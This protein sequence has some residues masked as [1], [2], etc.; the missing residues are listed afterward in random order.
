M[1]SI[2]NVQVMPGWTDEDI[3]SVAQDRAV[4]P[5]DVTSAVF[6]LMIADEDL[7]ANDE[8]RIVE[9]KH[10]HT[11]DRVTLRAKKSMLQT[12]LLISRTFW[13]SLSPVRICRSWQL[14]F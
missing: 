10:A 8:N 7:Q 6:Y 13:R 1:K 9:C 12:S 14:R 3:P 11:F 4:I 5:G 2:S